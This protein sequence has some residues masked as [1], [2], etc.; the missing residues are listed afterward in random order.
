MNRRRFLQTA[1]SGLLLAGLA[2]CATRPPSRLAS[3]GT[4][5]MDANAFR[6]ERRYVDLPQGR[7]AYVERG[8]GPAA[9]FLHGFPL[10]SFQWRGVLPRLAAYRRCIAPDSLGLGYTEVADGQSVT[11]AAQVEMLIALLDR[12][13]VDQADV[14]ASD[15]GGAVAQLLAIAHPERVRSLL[16][17]NCDVE[18]DSPPPA[19]I[20]VIEAAHAGRFAD[21]T[22]R[23]QLAD[24]AF[25]RSAQG[26]GGLCY[27]WPD[28]LG[29]ETIDYYFQP[30]VATPRRSA[31]TNAYAIGLSPNP[32][33]GAEAALRRCRIPARILW[34][35]GDTIFSPACPDYLARL[36]PLSRGVRRIEGA[37]LFFPEELPQLVTEEALRLW[38]LA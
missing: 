26:I 4:G 14:V 9:L 18:I 38:Q 37:K 15:S 10:N 16:F 6:T 29:D 27:T 12:L 34:G 31:L 2:A 17:T 22:F 23:P 21:D 1:G 19:V 5:D 11:P 33:A 7:I 36:L 35:T 8:S 13:G 30:L 3:A 25:A 32:L 28:Q 24:K 20:P